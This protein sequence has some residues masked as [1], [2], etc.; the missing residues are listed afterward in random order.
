ME[1]EGLCSRLGSSSPSFSLSL[2]LSLSSK[3]DFLLEKED[4]KEEYQDYI[5]T[6]G[7]HGC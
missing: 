4:L 3:F 1:N 2:S 5:F 7:L 6:V